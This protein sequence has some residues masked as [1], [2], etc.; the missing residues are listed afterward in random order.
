M[1]PQHLFTLFELD[2]M[3]P[4]ETINLF[5]RVLRISAGTQACGVHNLV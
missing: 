5:T 2:W 3:P 1:L 4:L